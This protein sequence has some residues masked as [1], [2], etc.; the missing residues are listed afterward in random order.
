MF[1]N[2]FPIKRLIV[3]EC[4]IQGYLETSIFIIVARFTR[5][6]PYEYHQM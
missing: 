1:L 4:T 5:L 6:L 2:L 3:F